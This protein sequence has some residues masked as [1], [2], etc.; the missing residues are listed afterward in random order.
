MAKSN[1]NDEQNC[2]IPHLEQFYLP[3]QKSYV[4]HDEGLI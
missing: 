3:V 4:P 2:E 1:P